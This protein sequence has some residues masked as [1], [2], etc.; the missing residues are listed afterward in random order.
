MLGIF[1]HWQ[2]PLL[3]AVIWS[4]MLIAMLVAW[5]VQGKPEYKT[6]RHGVTLV[7]IS[8]IGATRLQ[9]LFI[10]CA[11]VQGVLYVLSL[12]AERYLRHAGRLVPN[13]RRR[14]KVC[15]AL[16]IFCSIPG[17]LGILLVAVFNTV[18]HPTTHVAMLVLFLIGTGL[19][20]VFQT[21]EYVAL[22]RNYKESNK[23]RITTFLKIVWL[24]IALVLAICFLVFRGRNR[25]IAAGFE[26]TLAF[27]YSIYL[28][29]F[30]YDLYP[31]ARTRKGALLEKDMGQKVD[32]AAS[33]IPGMQQSADSD[34]LN[35]PSN[36]LDQ[37]VKNEPSSASYYS[38]PGSSPVQSMPIPQNAIVKDNR[39][40]H[41]IV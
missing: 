5:S 12:A 13:S 8:D 34:T 29:I 27:W 17:Q 9:T 36:E 33:W 22:D 39:R 14:E 23:L 19:S 26:W 32:R 35:P 4:G 15:S 24:L 41:N 11:A 30:S 21:L 16:A 28:V 25:I 10:V 18:D 37:E 1:S 40:V 20:I 38:S 6:G 7:Y 2:L 31:A 3:C